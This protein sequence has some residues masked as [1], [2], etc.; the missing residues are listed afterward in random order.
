[1]LPAAS[2]HSPSVSV[3]VRVGAVLGD[4][5]FQL[6]EPSDGRSVRAG[7]ELQKQP[8]LLL[9][10]RVDRFPEVSLGEKV[11]AG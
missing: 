3:P 9:P 10:E 7:G 4:D 2:H 5:H 1:M 11:K 8:L 6:A